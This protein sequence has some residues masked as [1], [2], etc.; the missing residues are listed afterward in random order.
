MSQNTVYQRT[1]LDSALKDLRIYEHQCLK[2]GKAP[3]DS[4]LEKELNNVRT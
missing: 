3:P 2:F 4:V 1:K